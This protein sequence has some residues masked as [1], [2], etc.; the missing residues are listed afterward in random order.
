MTFNMK[1]FSI[2]HLQEKIIQVDF[3]DYATY[4]VEIVESIS[5]VMP[6]GDVLVIIDVLYV[7][8]FTKIYFYFHF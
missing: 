4:L 7:P 8:S 3:G 1:D 5:L 2:L 6:S